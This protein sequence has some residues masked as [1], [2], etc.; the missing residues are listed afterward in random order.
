VEIIQ[1]GYSSIEV[2]S[3]EVFT[4]AKT[5]SQSLKAGTFLQP[6][7]DQVELADGKK[8][9]EVKRM[10]LGI[11]SAD[12]DDG[13]DSAY[14][15]IKT[16]EEASTPLYFRFRTIG[17]AY[18]IIKEILVTVIR[19]LNAIG[20]FCAVRISGVVM[21]ETEDAIFTIIPASLYPYLKIDSTHRLKID[22]THW[23]RIQ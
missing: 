10:E 4:D 9:S 12:V 8:Y 18:I 19:E 14:T 15:F 16:A 6:G 5:I 7:T 11:R 20:K 23:L 2:A 13:V 22:S 21:K 1:G 17:G 3:D